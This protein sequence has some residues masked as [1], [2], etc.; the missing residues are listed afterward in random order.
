M[1]TLTSS[2]WYAGKNERTF[3]QHKIPKNK[4]V[5]VEE[6]SISKT[7]DAQETILDLLQTV[8][9]SHHTGSERFGLTLLDLVG[10][11]RKRTDSVHVSSRVNSGSGGLSDRLVELETPGND[12]SSSILSLIMLNIENAVLSVT[13]KGKANF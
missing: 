9:A 12:T 6:C 10:K 3:L 13:R 4:R 2:W 8:E 5:S 7:K 1:K 11:I